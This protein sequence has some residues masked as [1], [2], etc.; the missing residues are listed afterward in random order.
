MRDD[1]TDPEIQSEPVSEPD[2]GVSKM[3]KTSKKSKRGSSQTGK[4]SRFNFTIGQKLIGVIFLMVLMLAL[5]AGTGIMQMKSIGSEIEEIAEQDMPLTEA[6]TA[7]TI[8]QLEQAINF[9]RMLRYGE[10]MELKES[11]R[12]HFEEAFEKFE[13][14]T[15][16]VDV[17]IVETEE[18]AKGAIKAANTQAAREEFEHVLAALEKIEGEH[19]DYEKNVEHVHEL[20]EAGEI[21]EAIEAA[22]SIEVEEEELD[23]ELEALLLEIEK[24]TD[25][26]LKTA[27]E[28][29]V[30]GLILMMIV[31]AAGA[32]IGFGIAFTVVRYNVIRPLAEMV[33]IIDALAAGDTSATITVRTND[34]IGQV[35]KA[36]Q[37]LQEQLIEAEMRRAEQ[38]TEQEAKV[39][40]A[41]AIE[42]M[43]NE[44]DKTAA[45]ALGAVSSAATEMQSTAESMSATAEQTN[46]QASAVAT[47]SEQATNNVQT[48]ASAS[49]EMAKSI[50]EI[51]RQVEKSSSIANRAVEETDRTN[52]SVEGL[53]QAAQK[54]GDVVELITN[55]AE[56]T[57]LLAL[58]ATIEA[59]R[60]GDAGKGF[61]VVASEVKS[62]ANQTAKATDEIAAQISGMQDATGGT[63]EAIK[64]ISATIGEI[65]EI[66]SAIASA[67]EEQGAATQEISRNVQ[68]AASGTQEVSRNIAG[69]TEGAGETG[70]ASGQVLDAAKQLSQQSES[71]RGHV[72]KFLADI[73]AA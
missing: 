70:K 28:H 19:A 20:I 3:S 49:E 1:R 7:I 4:V 32:I 16:K 2:Q 38:A 35:A 23:A 48:V 12:A 37:N 24:F 59:A 73:K 55:I 51:G 60:A 54:I 71:L 43:I 68:E 65:S 31:S 56:Q 46:K 33:K 72:D 17:E 53:A 39:K 40:R 57:N 29:E 30:F 15:K 26:S 50:E 25:E 27:E 21:T 45:D 61:A 52:T 14:L 42:A 44:F 8:H 64:G 34:E 9:E 10:E 69:V 36:A 22:E 62:L 41:E 13:V 58:N 63:V 67:V 18:L 6:I 47:A 11:A 66:A 5:V